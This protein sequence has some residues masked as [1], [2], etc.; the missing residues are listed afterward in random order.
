MKDFEATSKKKYAVRVTVEPGICGFS[1]EIRA[2]RE[3][4]SSARVKIHSKCEHIQLLA[5]LLDDVI[6]IKELFSP[7]SRN[8]IYRSVERGGCHLSCPIPTGVIKACEVA[9]DLALPK[10]VTIRIEKD[11]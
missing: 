7:L 10:D 6:T 1:C 3:G 2:R 8:R 5:T 11:A 9:M 4:S